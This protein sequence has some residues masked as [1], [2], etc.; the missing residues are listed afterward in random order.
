MQPAQ[1][2]LRSR[3]RHAARAEKARAEARRPTRRVWTFLTGDRDEMD[4]FAARFGVV[5]TRD[6]NDARDITHN[7]R[8]AIVDREGTS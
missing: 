8:T 6:M 5:I 1:R 2:Q 3:H 7:L 4:Q